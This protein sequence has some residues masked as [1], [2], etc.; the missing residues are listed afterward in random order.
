MKDT[1]VLASFINNIRVRLLAAQEEA[2]QYL[3][4]FLPEDLG[5]LIDTIDQELECLDPWDCDK[6]EPVDGYSAVELLRQLDL[7]AGT[8][9]F[10]RSKRYEIDVQEIFAAFA[11]AR[12]N[13]GLHCLSG[14]PDLTDYAAAAE[15]CA[16]AFA[17]LHYG[18]EASMRAAPVVQQELRAIKFSD[19]ARKGGEAKK[20]NLAEVEA[21]V[22]INEFI[23]IQASGDDFLTEVVGDKKKGYAIRRNGKVNVEAC[24]RLIYDRYTK[25]GC[26][27][28]YIRKSIKKHLAGDETV[29]SMLEPV[30][31]VTID[32]EYPPNVYPTKVVATPSAD[33]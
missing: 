33:A 32:E 16:D 8:W 21:T 5:Y 3:G 24:A 12:A 9:V 10:E 22:I 11:F 30:A 23:K 29:S 25:L 31:E 2:C 15:L 26:E 17:A 6:D 4:D 19:R 7:D 13:E 18:H 27:M 14:D 28:G 1:T 20:R